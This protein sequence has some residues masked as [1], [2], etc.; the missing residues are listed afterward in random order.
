MGPK[1][2]T[3]EYVD[4]NA[5]RPREKPGVYDGRVSHGPVADFHYEIT[6]YTFDRPGRHT[7]Q[8]RGG[9][10]P[11][12]EPLGLTSN[13]LTIEVGGAKTGN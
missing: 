3:E 12:K 10:H 13:V 8:W 4:G 1:P 9:G 6:E 11:I 5:N 7:I 2:V